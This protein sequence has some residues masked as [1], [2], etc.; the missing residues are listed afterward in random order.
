MVPL[1]HTHLNS[2][3]STVSPFRLG[4]LLTEKKEDAR[5]Y[6]PTMLRVAERAS[7]T[8]RTWR[9]VDIMK[10]LSQA[11]YAYNAAWGRKS[12]ASLVNSAARGSNECIKHFSQSHRFCLKNMSAVVS[13]QTFEVGR[14]LT[15][16]YRYEGA[17]GR[18]ISLSFRTSNILSESFRT[19]SLRILPF[20]IVQIYEILGELRI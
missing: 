20:G 4:V 9:S 2:S 17:G 12:S 7:P 19:S 18:C 14:E 5:R 13:S 15:V 3:G 11:V 1:S 6:K 8:L 10:A 16:L